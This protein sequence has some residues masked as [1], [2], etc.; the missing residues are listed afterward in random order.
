ML[1]LALVN[2]K[3]VICA[4]DKRLFFFLKFDCFVVRTPTFLIKVNVLTVW[5]S[6]SRKDFI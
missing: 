4:L 6:I 2:E 3:P 5:L 1:G